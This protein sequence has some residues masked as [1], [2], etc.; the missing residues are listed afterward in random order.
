M[1]LK[2]FTISAVHYFAESQ[3]NILCVGEMMNI[4]ADKTKLNISKASWVYFKWVIVKRILDFSPLLIIYIGVWYWWYPFK[5]IMKMLHDL[6]IISYFI[7]THELKST[8]GSS[9]MKDC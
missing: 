8:G 9:L 6:E 2:A 1:V 4:G 5:K 3:L 7:A